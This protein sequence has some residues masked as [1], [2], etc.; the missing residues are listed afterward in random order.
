METL[1]TGQILYYVNW[2][3]YPTIHEAKI[4]SVTPNQKAVKV[5]LNLNVCKAYS[6]GAFQQ[7]E[8]GH[9][10]FL[11]EKAARDQVQ[12]YMYEILEQAQ[13]DMTKLTSKYIASQTQT[14]K[15]L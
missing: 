2:T 7:F 14:I 3:K 10:Y 5:E 6:G 12:D 11:T 15:P 13:K 8:L 9:K 4:T 1:K